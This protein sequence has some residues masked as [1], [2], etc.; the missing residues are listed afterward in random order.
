MWTS[1]HQKLSEFHPTWPA[2][3]ALHSSQGIS[4]GH[5]DVV[6]APAGAR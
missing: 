1:L 4:V 3:L 5:F 6:T 2:G